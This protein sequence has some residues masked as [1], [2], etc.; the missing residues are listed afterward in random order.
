MLNKL[1]NYL[2][3]MN[4]QIISSFQCIGIPETVAKS[5]LGVPDAIADHYNAKQLLESYIDILCGTT[6]PKIT[7]Y[8][9]PKGLELSEEMTRH[10]E[11]ASDRVGGKLIFRYWIVE[12]YEIVVEQQFNG[13]VVMDQ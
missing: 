6:T 8:E 1:P 10:Y 3:T 2:E 11:E 4:T 9:I 7:S 5:I 13:F 12:Q